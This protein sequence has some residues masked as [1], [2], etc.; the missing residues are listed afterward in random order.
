MNGT[1]HIGASGDGTVA[2]ELAQQCLENLLTESFDSLNL[3]PG[4]HYDP[5]N[6]IQTAYYRDWN[7]ED[8]VPIAGCKRITV[9]VRWPGESPTRSVTLVGIT[10]QTGH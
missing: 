2:V 6:P 5:G 7:V 9:N 4:A 10:A 8:G 3:D 1:R